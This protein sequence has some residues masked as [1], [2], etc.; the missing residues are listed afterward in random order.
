MEDISNLNRYSGGGGDH[1]SSDEI[2]IFLNQILHRSA[3]SAATQTVPLSGYPQGSKCGIYGL[4]S[5]DVRA[6]AASLS[7]GGVSENETDEY[8][9]ESEEGMEAFVGELP[10]KP[11]GSRGS[12]KRSRAAEVH[13]LSEKRRRSRI[14]EKMKA[15]Q[16]LIP[17]SNK[18]DKASMLD[19]AIEYLK[20]LQLQVQMLSMRNGISSHPMCLP[21]LLQPIRLSQFSRGFTKDNRCQQMNIVGSVSSNQG[22]SEQTTPYDLPKECTVSNQFSLPNMSTILSSETPFGIN[23]FI[24]AHFDP[25]PLPATSGEIGR[26]DG[27]PHPHFNTEHSARIPSVEVARETVP[28][29]F[30][31]PLQASNLKAIGSSGAW[32]MGKD[33]SEYVFMKG[34]QA[35]NRTGSDETKIERHHI[36]KICGGAKRNDLPS[37][38][39][40]SI[41]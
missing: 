34:I 24:R 4:N 32:G 26:V 1:R 36:W 25:F 7:I 15:L 33:Q 14:N 20:Q 35:G 5:G 12:S 2:S 16:N 41:I 10:V 9:C 21:G 27:F 39:F 31:T 37:F 3:S 8:D 28:R 19:E 17:N 40:V 22:D 18:T 38:R 13:N 23:S 6:N 30:E 29:L 11:S